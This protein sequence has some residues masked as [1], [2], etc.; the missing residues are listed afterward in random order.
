MI[1]S[2]FN[3]FGAYAEKRRVAARDLVSGGGEF[4][5]AHR[6]DVNHLAAA[7][8]HKVRVRTHVGVEMLFVIPRHDHFRHAVSDKFAQVAVNRRYAYV[9]YDFFRLRVNPIRR[10]MSIGCRKKVVHRFS[11]FGIS[12]K[13]N[14]FLIDNDYHYNILLRDFCKAF[15]AKKLKNFLFAFTIWRMTTQEMLAPFRR[16][17]EDYKMIED[18]DKIAVGVSGGKDSLTLLALMKAFQRF[19]PNKFELTAITID[20]GFDKSGAQFDKV[21]QYCDGIGVPYYVERTDIG[22]ILFD[23]RKETSPCSLCSKMRRGAL[24]TKLL[25]LGCNKLALGHHAEDTIETF[26]LS[27]FYEGRLSTFAP[28]SYMDRTGVSMIR[29]MIY[30]SENDIAAYAKN[31]PVVF[32]PCPADKHTKREYMKELI[33]T[34][35]KDIPFVKDRMLGAISHPDRY[36]LWDKVLEKYTAEKN[37]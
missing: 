23:V 29:P 4:C 28:I 3:T 27:L 24:N 22:E 35:Q 10:G 32:N 37:K 33:K 30:I 14:S 13:H 21:R 34:I 19:S 18:G 1:P 6:F 7:A 26:L 11:L 25:A 31:L 16:A 9:G 2:F 20:L 12:L 5:F 17:I 15:R 8:A 36:N